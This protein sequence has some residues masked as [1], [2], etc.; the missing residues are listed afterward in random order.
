MATA[1]A[2]TAER[3][4][5]PSLRV[6]VTMLGPPCSMP[7]APDYSDENATSLIERIAASRDKVAFAALFR[8]FAPRIKS[9]LV[10]TGTDAEAAEEIAQETMIVVWSKAA[11]FDRQRAAPSTW[12][13]T[14]ARNKRID[15]ARQMGRASIDVDEY[16]LLA[17]EPPE[18][19]DQRALQNETGRRVQA[20]L[21]ILSDEHVELIRKAFFEDKSH[22]AIASE[23]RLPLGTVKSRIR[24]ALRQLRTALEGGS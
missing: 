12:V 8:M 21:S 6:A 9:F 10:R 4:C 17:T 11:F 18:A 2:S 24:L 23:L 19:T 14:I 16:T 20:S 3:G 5:Q 15:R 1:L 13:F 22:T 7:V